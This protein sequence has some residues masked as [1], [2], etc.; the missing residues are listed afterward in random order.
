M[1][2]AERRAMWREKREMRKL[3]R[4]RA[5]IGLVVVAISIWVGFL[6]GSMWFETVAL[7]LL[8]LMIFPF[9]ASDQRVEAEWKARQAARRAAD[10]GQ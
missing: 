6:G 4:V 7:V 1:T 9:W 5:A 8:A 3:G 10:P 2:F